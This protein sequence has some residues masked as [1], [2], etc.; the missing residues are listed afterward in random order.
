[1]VDT[2][3]PAGVLQL[4]TLTWTKGTPI[5]RLHLDLY[6]PGQFNPGLKGNARFSPIRDARGQPIPT[7]YGGTSFDCAAMETVFHDVPFAAGLKTYDKGKLHGQ[8]HS[9]LLSAQDLL[10]VDLGSKAL[11]KLGV[12][13]NQLIDTEKDQYPQTRLWAE[14]IYRQNT[15]VQGLCWTSRQDDSA[16]ALMLFGDRLAARALKP[17]GESRRVLEDSAAYGELLHLAEQIGVL[18]VA[19]RLG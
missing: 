13:R 7:L 8:L 3:A 19:G 9:V 14:A 1:M 2:P 18:L 10:L 17:Q 4:S 11:R 15:E 12:P 16:R 5:H 6:G